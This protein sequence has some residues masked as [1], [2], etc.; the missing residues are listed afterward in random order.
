MRRARL[1]GVSVAVA[2]LRHKQCVPALPSRHKTCLLGTRKGSDIPA[3]A[4]YHNLV[5]VVVTRDTRVRNE[6]FIAITVT[7]IVPIA[8]TVAGGGAR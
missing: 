4:V 2:K 6:R 5:V 7:V 1:P 3:S 8:V